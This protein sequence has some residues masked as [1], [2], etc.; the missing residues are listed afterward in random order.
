MLAPV[1][2]EATPVRDDA[3]VRELCAQERWHDAATAILQAH[4][5]ELLSYLVAIARSE[6]DGTDAFSQFCEDLWRALPKFRWEASARVWCYVLARHALSRVRRRER[7]HRAAEPDGSGSGE[8]AKLA[9]QIRSTTLPFLRSEVKDRLVELR[10]R[11]EPDDQALLILRIDRK[12][13]WLD[14]ARAL[15][16]SEEPGPAEL[17]RSSAALRKRFERLKAQLRAQM[18]ELVADGG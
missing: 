11:L 14:V 2:G 1:V 13:A 15:S 16:D 8:I 5:H 3:V 12:L 7:R 6:A 10:E 4:G 9:E 17:N 18:A